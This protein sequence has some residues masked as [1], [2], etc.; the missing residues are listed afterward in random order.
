MVRVCKRITGKWWLR[1]CLISTVLLFH[2]LFVPLSAQSNS[3][4][5]VSSWDDIRQL[6][7]D[8]KDK[9]GSRG[10]EI[11]PLSPAAIGGT[12]E[13]WSDRPLFLWQGEARRIALYMED[14]RTIVWQRFAP[15]G[16]GSASYT[17]KALQ[18]GATYVWKVF[19]QR[20]EPVMVLPFRVMDAIRREQVTTDLIA[21]ET[22]FAS[23]EGTAEQLSL[24][25]TNYFISNRLMS[26]ALQ[27]IFSIKQPS[28]ELKSL[29]Q[30]VSTQFCDD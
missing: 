24:Q 1:L 13:I 6:L 26:D 14:G 17:G 29:L 15:I 2:S 21:L 5:V 19:T 28:T 12:A 16:R 10:D 20:S 8:E 11:C 23:K 18:P 9:G 22:Q 7:E 25:R 27:E 4:A 30:Q 3:S